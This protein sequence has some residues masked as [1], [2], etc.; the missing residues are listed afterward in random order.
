MKKNVGGIDKTV[1]IAAGVVIIIL[2]IVYNSWWGLIGLIPL[3]TGL[4]NSCPLY[5]PFGISTCKTKAPTEQA[6]K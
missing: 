3:A 5:M 4:I 6:K 1:R 2:G